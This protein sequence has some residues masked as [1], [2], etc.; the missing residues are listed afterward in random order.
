MTQAE[1]D[2]WVSRI[3]YKPGWEIWAELL[4]YGNLINITVGYNGADSTQPT[5]TRPIHHSQLCSPEFLHRMATGASAFDVFVSQVLQ[6]LREL[7]NHE[8]REFFRVDGKHRGDFVP[9]DP[10]H[11]L[12]AV[13]DG[14]L[15]PPFVVC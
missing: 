15:T 1:L 3:S 4:D 14:P 8:Q 5:R 12:D 2:E 6:T 11:N 10:Q 7:E 9:H 13:Y